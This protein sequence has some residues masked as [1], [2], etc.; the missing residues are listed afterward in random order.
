MLTRVEKV[1]AFVVDNFL[2]GD[3]AGLENSA[4]LLDEGIVDST[5]ILELIDFL[6]KEFVIKVED[7]E[8]LPDNLDSIDRMAA[9]IDRKTAP[10]SQTA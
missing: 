3:A 9:Y 5:G 10:A 7:D 4:S 8:L 2:F 6:E 1:R